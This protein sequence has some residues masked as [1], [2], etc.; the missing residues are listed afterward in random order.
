MDFKTIF[1]FTVIPAALFGGAIAA[2][3]SKL[4]R[5]TF[6]VLLVFMGPMIELWDINFVS[7]EWY[8][9][10]SRGFEV[11]VL[12]IMSFSLLSACLLR[13]RRG[14][15]RIFWPASLFPILL[16]FLYA[17][18]NVAIN[19]PRLF[20]Y[21]ELF[22]MVRGIVLL[23]AIAFYLR[24]ERELRLLVYSLAALVCY[25]GLLAVK[26]RYL[27]G[28]NR[29]PG[30]IDDSN[31]LSVFIVMTAPVLVAAV[32]CDFPK[33]LKFLCTAGIGLAIIAEILTISRAGVVI[34]A[35]ML[36][37]TTL[38]TTTYKVT[39]K[40]L[41]I[42]FLVLICVGGITAKSW[43][44]LKERFGS[45]TLE[46]EYGKHHNLGRGYYIREAKAMVAE[47]PL[48]VGLNNWS[49]WAS[50]KYGP[51]LGY[52][53]VHYRGVDKEPSTI[54][55]SGSNVDE[56]Q[57]APAHCLAA[58]TAG[59]L[60]YPGL[61]FFAW[62]WLR[63]FQMGASFLWPRTP[64]PLRRMGVG[65]LFGFCGIFLQSLTEWVFRQSPIYYVFHVLLGALA[66]LYFMKKRDKRLAA[67]EPD[68]A[69]VSPA[70]LGQME[71]APT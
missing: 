68:Q 63:W 46:Q 61:F 66:S 15:Q 48:G 53:F 69:E 58:L 24:S 70:E 59:E 62:L 18:F 45:S 64:D 56:A 44:S 14:E 22:K 25:E 67:E 54:I 41:A 11:S 47:Q 42:C 52:K 2:T 8:R 51:E 30:T 50:D 21:F 40:K 5:D 19:E 49:Y 43:K 16:F 32:N 20:G 36:A 65:I 28:I 31:S 23:L 33:K 9:G 57:A 6:F 37:L 7:R 26:Q 4:V 38:T 10:T 35:S 60:G 71:S 34:L 12:D 13:P 55:P 17:C 39:P 3:F 27:L 29:V 1:G